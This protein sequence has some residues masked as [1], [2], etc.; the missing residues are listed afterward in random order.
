MKR[1]VCAFF[2]LVLA[3]S[4]YARAVLEA[5][6][7]PERAGKSY[8]YGLIIGTDLKDTGIDFDYYAV[9]QGLQDAIEGRN[10][11]MSVDEAINLVQQS[12]FA[13]MEQQA[14]ENRQKEIQFFV[15][16]GARAGVTTTPSGLQYEVVQA[17]GGAKPNPQATVLVQYEG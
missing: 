5:D 1:C 4:L 14:A 8:A 13:A 15:E 16:N 9:A 12:F 3:S 11:R 7:D 6:A 2:G 10:P 17:A